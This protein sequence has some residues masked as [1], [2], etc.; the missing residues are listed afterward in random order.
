MC[1]LRTL[2]WTPWSTIEQ[3]F[4][5][6]QL[7]AKLYTDLRISTSEFSDIARASVLLPPV[8]VNKHV[9][10]SSYLVERSPSFNIYRL[11]TI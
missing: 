3:G 11:Y 10:F 1:G 9:T 6:P 2:V 5:E 4:L 7:V 8:H